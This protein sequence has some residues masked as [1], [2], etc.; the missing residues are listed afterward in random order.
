MLTRQGGCAGESWINTKVQMTGRAR[1]TSSLPCDGGGKGGFKQ[2]RGAPEFKPG[3]SRACL[4]MRVASIPQES[5]CRDTTGPLLRGWLCGMAMN[6]RPPSG[7]EI[8]FAAQAPPGYWRRMPLSAKA[9]SLRRAA[10]IKALAHPSRLLIADALQQGERCV[11]DLRA[12]VGADLSTVS[13]HLSVMRRAGLL[14]MEKRGLNV[15][16]RL[17]CP[18]LMDF[19][20]CVDSLAPAKPA[21]RRATAPACV[22]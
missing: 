6:P 3:L 22:C 13:K 4:L 1:A 7:G 20:Q 17:R 9:L 12:L 15:Y 2:T 10:V 11:C 18:C 8:P 21:R 5:G 14:E 16:Y 19:F